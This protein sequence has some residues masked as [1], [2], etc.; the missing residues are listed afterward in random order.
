MKKL[1]ERV[2]TATE[3][4]IL[5]AIFDGIGVCNIKAK[6]VWNISLYIF[7]R[8]FWLYYGRQHKI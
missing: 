8:I 2:I 1:L 3:I 6:P 5:V 7:Y 4:A